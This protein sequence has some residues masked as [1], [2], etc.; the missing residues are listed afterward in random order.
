MNERQATRRPAGAAGRAWLAA[1]GAALAAAHAPGALAAGCTLT[2]VELPV[3]IV[4]HRAIATVGING[5]DVQM[6]V[7]SGAWFSTMPD[8]AAAQLHLSPHHVAGFAV[9]GI[10]GGADARIVSTSLKLIK[11]TLPTVEF[12]V[13]GNDLGNGVM[14]LLG[15][16]ILSHAD[17]EY[18]LAHGVIRFVY[19]GDGCANANMAYW[20]GTQPVSMLPLSGTDSSRVAP[21]I[22]TIKVNGEPV[23]ALFDT[24]AGTMLSLGAARR[25]GVKESDMKDAGRFGGIG[26]GSARSW[27]ASFARVEIGAEAIS[28]NTLWIGDFD[29]RGFD[30]LLGMDFFLSHHLYVSRKQ[31]RLY[32]T[33]EGGPVFARNVEARASGP[34]AADAGD[35]GLDADALVRRAE[36]L[37][38]RGNR[39][40]ALADLDRACRLD[41]RNA[42]CLDD[43]AQMHAADKAFDKAAA[44][45]DEALRIAPDL[46]HARLGRAALRA[47]TGDRAGALSDLDILDK[48]LAPQS[49]AR[50]ELASVFGH[51]GEPGRAVAQIDLWIASHPRDG[52]L[53]GAYNSRC[54]QR[55]VAG[56]ELDKALADCNESLALDPDVPAHVDSRAWVWLRMG[57][58]QKARAE[59]DHALQL[60]ADEASSLYGRSIARQRLGDEAGGA[61]DL[62]AARKLDPAMEAELQRDGLA[63]D[64]LAAH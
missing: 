61:A 29:M 11:G 23:D 30:M 7:D 58:W 36:A 13:G 52:G 4:D 45:Y 60:R 3:H 44:D 41:S 51:A 12:V 50:L 64:R 6:L 24:G 18:D 1:L 46:A 25:L 43:R 63:P 2:T 38:A 26:R 27:T 16:N 57:Q 5:H 15:R 22:A 39:A 21:I 9:T 55:V 20:A 8:A 56:R 54:W 49:Q 37:R 53:P 47:R 35:D 17:T 32:F 40:A 59:F 34:A 31:S 33:Y 10:T 19:P 62:A 28:N 14:G 48:A 42:T